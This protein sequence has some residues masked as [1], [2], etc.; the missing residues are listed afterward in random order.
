MPEIGDSLPDPGG[1]TYY[2]PRE[3][4][5]DDGR[6]KVAYKNKKSAKSARRLSAKRYDKP[7]LLKYDV[8]RCP[9]CKSYHLGAK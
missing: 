6:P 7:E 1:Y 5:N 4:Y 3:C 9:H 8:Y 2:R